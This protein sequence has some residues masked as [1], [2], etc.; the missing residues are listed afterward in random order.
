MWV[1]WAPLDDVLVDEDG[2]H[3]EVYIKSTHPSQA[4]TAL[5]A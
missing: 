3:N 2:H 5:A 4:S 1:C